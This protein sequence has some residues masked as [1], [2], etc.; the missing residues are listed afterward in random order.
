VRRAFI[1]AAFY[2]NPKITIRLVARVWNISPTYVKAALAA[3]ADRQFAIMNGIE[4]LVPS[5]RPERLAAH[6][7]RSSPAEL[8]AAAAEVGVGQDL[9]FYDRAVGLVS[10]TAP[11]HAVRI[12]T[13]IAP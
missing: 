6:I 3:D 13:C 7:E 10:V 8:K 11:A 2:R 9:E 4:A 5:G 1:A 12:K